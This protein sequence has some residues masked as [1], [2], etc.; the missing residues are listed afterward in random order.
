MTDS[1]LWRI[2]FSPIIA[3]N[4]TCTTLSNGQRTMPSTSFLASATLLH[5][6]CNMYCQRGTQILNGVHLF[7]S[8]TKGKGGKESLP[9]HACMQTCRSI[10]VYLTLPVYNHVWE[11]KGK[12][13][14]CFVLFCFFFF[15][16]FVEEIHNIKCKLVLRGKAGVGSYIC[17]V[18]SLINMHDFLFFFGWNE[19][20]WSVYI[21]A[22]ISAIFFLKF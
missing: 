16:V 6:S 3:L 7:Y 14:F 2:T 20:V 9:L 18:I 8:H 22:C 21:Y 13:D 19:R 1:G 5:C 17:H 12:K 10:V 11:K 15:F 4:A